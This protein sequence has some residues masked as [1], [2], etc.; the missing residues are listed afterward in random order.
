MIEDH[1]AR[2]LLHMDLIR[3]GMLHQRCRIE[4]A[5]VYLDAMDASD[6]NAKRERLHTKASCLF[7]AS[8]YGVDEL[9][10]CVVTRAREFLRHRLNIGFLKQVVH[11]L[12]RLD[13]IAPLRRPPP[14]ASTPERTFPPLV[15]AALLCL[16]PVTTA[17]S[18]VC[19]I[20]P[21]TH[22]A[23]HACFHRMAE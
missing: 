1:E 9:D 7:V 10:K 23:F 13:K 20:R 15:I 16:E 5:H 3:L 19:G 2:L 17:R 14:A 12:H 21:L 11:P 18:H 8:G 4:L 22:H 6:D